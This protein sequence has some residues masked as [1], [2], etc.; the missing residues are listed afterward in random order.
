MPIKLGLL[1][2]PEIYLGLSEIS[3]V[4]LG[5][6]LVWQKTST[7]PYQQW[8]GFPDSPASIEDYPYQFI[9]FSLLLYCSTSPYFVS[10]D[11]TYTSAY[12]I[13]YQLTNGQWELINYSYP[14]Y[15]NFAK[16][17]IDES[18]NDIYTDST[19]TTVYFAKTT[20]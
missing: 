3:K 4:Y 20:A 9:Q 10:G 14:P 12:S 16:G 8:A 15:Y 6:N 2:V 7:S 1:D 11:S 17:T 5:S 19:L 18:N 13:V